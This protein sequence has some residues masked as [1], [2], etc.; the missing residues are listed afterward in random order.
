VTGIVQSPEGLPS[1]KALEV[2]CRESSKKFSEGV[3]RATPQRISSLD[4]QLY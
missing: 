4:L 2:S 1:R 3:R